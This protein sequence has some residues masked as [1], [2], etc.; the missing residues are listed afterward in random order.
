MELS[1]F[2]LMVLEALIE[3]DPEKETIKQQLANAVVID[4]DYTG[5][6]LFTKIGIS[7]SSPIFSKSNRYIEKTPKTHLAHPELETGAGVL[8][9][10]EDGKVSA[11]ECYTYEEDWPENESLFTISA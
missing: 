10:F 2:E 7:E 3:T 5:V 9:W 11:L 8:L 6:G 4:R 1:K